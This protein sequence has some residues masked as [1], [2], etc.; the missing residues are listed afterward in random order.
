MQW[1]EQLHDKGTLAVIR[2]RGEVDL[3]HS[4][5]LRE[6]LQAKIAL[7]LPALLL[8]FSE[9]KY[10]DSSGLATLVEYF[11]HAR[12]YSGRLALVGMTDRVKSVF[13]LVR[14]NEIFEFY[15]SVAEACTRLNSTAKTNP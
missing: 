8:D 3:Q 5:K 13:D 12:A 9:V 14:L 10:I 7:R 2:L 4:P 1:D 6:I 11:Q 15:P